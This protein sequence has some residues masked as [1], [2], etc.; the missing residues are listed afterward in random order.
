[1]KKERQQ[2]RETAGFIKDPNSITAKIK[3]VETQSKWS[4]SGVRP[5]SAGVATRYSPIA[6]VQSLQ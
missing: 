6:R 4:A 1:M 3:D 5:A 2:K